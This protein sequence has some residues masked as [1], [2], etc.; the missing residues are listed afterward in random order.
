MCQFIVLFEV[1]SGLSVNAGLFFY[2]YNPQ[3]SDMDYRMF[4]MSMGSF[5]TWGDLGLLPHPKDFVESDRILTQEKT[6]K[7]AK[8]KR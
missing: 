8:P 1:A 7:Q 3:N 5:Y 6:G 2:S 4:N